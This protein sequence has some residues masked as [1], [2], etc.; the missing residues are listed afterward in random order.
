MNQGG[1]N[2]PALIGA[3][4]REARTKLNTMAGIQQPG[5]IMASSPQLM[6]AA[7]PR[8]P[9]RMV[10]APMVPPVMPAAPAIDSLPNIPMPTTVD[11]R[12]LNPMA[13]AVP[14]VPQPDSPTTPMKFQDAGPV[15]VN[16]QFEGYSNMGA[17]IGDRARASVAAGG[18]STVDI[19]PLKK[20][21]SITGKPAGGVDLGLDS[22]EFMEAIKGLTEEGVNDALKFFGGPA[23]VVKRDRELENGLRDVMSGREATPAKIA[24]KTLELAGVPDTAEGRMDFAETLGFDTN[25]IGALDDKIM[26]VLMAG[27]STDFQQAVLMGLQNYKSTAMARASAG[28]GKSGMSPLEPFIDAARDLAGKIVAATGKDLDVAFAE[29]EAVL[30][31]YYT[32]TGANAASGKPPPPSDDIDVILAEAKEAIRLQPENAEAIKKQAIQLGVPEGS[33]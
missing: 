17:Q 1:I 33:L 31:P 32:N 14:T 18:S 15:A 21:A 16:P 23:G 12:S 9:A 25:D 24:A 2:N 10:G 11:P 27:Q 4:Q 19:T 28:S 6:Q 3:S 29:A 30:K 22:P 20:A 26:E 13:S 8:S 5:G 7:M